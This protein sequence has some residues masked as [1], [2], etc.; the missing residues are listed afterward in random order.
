MYI[1]CAITY[2]S[3]TNP[4]LTIILQDD[5]TS[6]DGMV[7]RRPISPEVPCLHK[8]RLMFTTTTNSSSPSISVPMPEPESKTETGM[9]PCIGG[10]DLT[11]NTKVRLFSTTH[12][13]KFK[14][15]VGEI[16]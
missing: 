5:S 7:S 2:V 13:K 1:S 8:K 14:F 12:F 3:P 9:D 16:K 11:I 4:S 6:P 10:D 15:I